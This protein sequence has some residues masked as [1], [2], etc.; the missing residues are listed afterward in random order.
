MKQ[1]LLLSLI[2]SAHLL[3]M[4]MDE[5]IQKALTH[6]N[7]LKTLTYQTQQSKAIKESK[8]VQNYGKL[9]LVANYD[10]YNLAR[11]LAPLTPM[12][13]VGSVDGAYQIPATQDL[14]SGGISYNVTLF[15]GFAQKRS[16][17]ISDIQHKSATIKENLAKEELV[18]NVKNLY[19]SLLSLQEQLLAQKL[20]SDSQKRL[21]KQIEAAYTLGKH[22]RLDML[23]AKN[24]YFAS[25][26]VEEKIL[27]NIKILTASLEQ[28]IGGEPFD[29]AE[30]IQIN[31][32]EDTNTLSSDLSKL[33]KL[34]V[35]TLQSHI[36]SKK[37]DAT[38][39][40][41]YPIIDFGA[42]Y[43]YNL[44]PNAT[45]NTSPQTGITHIEKGEW[46][47]ENIWQTGIHLKWNIFD[48]GVR[49]SLVEK[50]ELS[51]LIANTKT[52]EM[53]LKLSK[54]LKVAKSKRQLAKNSYKMALN[55]YDLAVEIAKVE[56][57]KYDN[58]AA[59]ITDLLQAQ[60]K[61]KLL[62]AKSITAKYDYLK[63]QY[64]L[65]YLLERGL[66]K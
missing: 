20:F 14:M 53:K 17:E 56:Q 22:S 44:G 45:T 34:E 49:S 46:N 18:Y 64:A 21:Y 32:T 61:A 63:A 2:T 29:K 3:G 38:K 26:S 28:I 27:S 25:L 16:F 12:D 24:A 11:T 55:E 48:F 54:D 41:Y 51:K 62:L 40:L 43:G 39:A 4:N 36:A 5:T 7:T 42:Y 13:I 1:L 59:T 47:S 31:F 33:Q 57:T 65:D 19:V 58:N 35:Y 66:K 6:N 15:E 8:K 37:V 52:N 9:S 50:E 60:A 30:P 10:H 23:K